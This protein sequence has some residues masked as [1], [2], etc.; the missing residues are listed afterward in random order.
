M[1]DSI[2]ALIGDMKKNGMASPGD[3]IVV[4]TGTLNQKGATNLMRV[5]Y[6]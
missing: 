2:E 5:Q 6:A 3:A 1:D 4:V